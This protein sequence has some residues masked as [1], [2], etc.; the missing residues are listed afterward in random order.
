MVTALVVVF[1]TF[2][3]LACTSY[4]K[5][6]CG[7]RWLG[8]WFRLLN[9]QL[10]RRQSLVWSLPCE[11]TKCSNVSFL[12]VILKSSLCETNKRAQLPSHG[13]RN[14]QTKYSFSWL[15]HPY[16]Y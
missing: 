1:V 2:G 16:K 11:S 3:P 12:S 4:M 7:K 10:G 13:K 6:S 8:V 9:C 15:L 5:C 14:Q